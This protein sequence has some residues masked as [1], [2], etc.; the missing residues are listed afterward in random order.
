MWL[1][2]LAW[3]LLALPTRPGLGLAFWVVALAL[4]AASLRGW[5]GVGRVGPPSR[6]RSTG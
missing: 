2:G 4:T 5:W 1:L 6:C 3:W